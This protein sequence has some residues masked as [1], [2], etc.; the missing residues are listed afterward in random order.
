MHLVGL[1]FITLLTKIK[2][3]KFVR[4]VGFIE[5]KLA[6]EVVK[7]YVILLHIPKAGV[8]QSSDQELDGL[9]WG[10]ISIKGKRFLSSSDRL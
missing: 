5:K 10:S 1:D 7:E 4:L 2:F 9:N 6:T 3:G 8:F